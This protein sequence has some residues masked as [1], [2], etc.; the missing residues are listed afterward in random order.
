MR[1]S[2]SQGFDQFYEVGPGCRSLPRDAAPDRPKS[3]VPER[4]V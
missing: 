4:E 3:I 1:Y 2:I